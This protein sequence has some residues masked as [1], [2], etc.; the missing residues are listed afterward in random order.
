MNKVSYKQEDIQ[1]CLNA[2]SSM[3]VSGVRNAERIV[4]IAHLLLDPLKENDEG[5][6]DGSRKEE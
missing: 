3:E 1:A 2:L 5:E 6:K 4:M